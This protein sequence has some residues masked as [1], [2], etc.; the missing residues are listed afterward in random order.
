L[1]RRLDQR[2][3]PPSGL[4]GRDEELR[5]VLTA[6]ASRGCVVAGSAGVGKSRLASDAA[7]TLG[8]ERTV[9]RVVA[10][11]AAA[12]IP[13]GSVSHLLS[14]GTAP[15]IAEFVA[16]LRGGD[17]GPAPTLFVDDAHLLDDASA[18][19]LLAIANTGVAP[20][21]LTVR[22]HEPVPDALVAL[23]KDRY[24]D[25]V[26]LQAL[27]E[28]EVE[29]MVDD[30]LGAPSHALAY[31]WIYRVSQGNPLF[32]TEIVADVRRTGRLELRDGRWHLDEDRKP[33][34]RLSELLAS[35]IGSVSA[36]AHAALEVL[37]LGTPM[38]LSVFEDLASADALEELERARLA[39]I[40]HDG[41][42]LLVEVAHPLY[43]EVVLG[44]LPASAGRR[45]RRELAEALSDLG[46]DTPQERLAVARL[47]LESGQVDEDRFLEASSIALGLGAPDL[48]G[49]L[50]EAVAPSLRAALCLAQART[51]A[52]RFGDVDAV[53]APFEEEAATGKVEVAAAYVETRVR[54]LLRAGENLETIRPFIARFE[55]WHGTADWRA[56]TASVA[57][58]IVMQDNGWLEAAAIV[59]ASLADTDVG[60]ERRLQLLLVAAR[61]SARRGRVDDYD[62]IMAEVGR[63]MEEL[64]GRP[65]DRAI[66]AL[67]LEVARVGAARDLRGV[68]QRTVQHLEQARLR[69]EYFEYVW[70][71]YCLAHID[72]VQ[73]HHG[74]A[75]VRFQQ[76][77]DHLAAVDPLNIGPITDV[78]QSIT[79]AY[80]GEEQLARRTLGRAETAFE[81]MPSMGRSVAPDINRARA[82]LEM[83]AGRV[84]AAREQL[85]AAAATAG[86]D[87]LVASESLHVALLLG[88]DARHCAA[89]L[90]ALAVDAQDDAIHAWARH[91][92]AVADKDPTAQLAA[93]EAFEELGLDLDAAQAGALAAIGFRRDGLSAAA[94]RAG[95]LARRCADRCPGVRVPALAARPDAP[96]LTARE[97]EIAGL[98]A[99]GLSNPEIADALVLSVRSVETYVLRVYRKLGVRNRSDLS[100][101]LGVREN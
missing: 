7:A 81:R 50:A 88:A 26:D 68:R 53:L 78:M 66:N 98:A 29:Q 67:R 35:H 72:H 49:N 1:T 39:V 95:T 86:D 83:A 30:L 65:Y 89:G 3:N 101:A 55:Q 94:N 44:N 60:A 4:F 80:L 52:A 45:I 74:D 59:E 22:S 20:L 62:A 5:A 9:V 46:A 96:D 93:A 32:V 57:A 13:F 2:G 75:R 15:T 87:V 79:L 82:M 84:S 92:R 91:A 21:L 17:L 71:L 64:E 16:V 8:R 48:A 14:G 33:F 51:G 58:W 43:G 100:K 36:D 63:L 37:A 24:L 11:A 19:L 70:M 54:G 34:E 85:L 10:T 6:L 18:A 56:L 41:R 23:W 61:V 47:M 12:S 31:K 28:R 76:V 99:R 97:H 25:R 42:G 73:G 77:I 40:S 90:E 27:S 69:G 38:R